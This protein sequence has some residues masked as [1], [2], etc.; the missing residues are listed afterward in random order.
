MSA[1]GPISA[2]EIFVKFSHFSLLYLEKLI[3]IV[4]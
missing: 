4:A 2:V 1:I 3:I